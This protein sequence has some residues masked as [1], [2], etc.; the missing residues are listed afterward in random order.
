VYFPIH[1]AE[2][3]INVLLSSQIYVPNVVFLSSQNI[4]LMMF[5]LTSARASRIAI[6]FVYRNSFFLASSSI[7]P[8][9]TINTENSATSN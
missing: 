7:V 4:W 1:V 8:I 9:A 2:L 6:L 3:V 5:C